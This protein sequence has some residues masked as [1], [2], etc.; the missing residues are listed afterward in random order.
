M[1]CDKKRIKQIFEST[2]SDL[3]EG[4]FRQSRKVRSQRRK[5]KKRGTGLLHKLSSPWL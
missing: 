2:I 1:S 3:D 5:G 4:L